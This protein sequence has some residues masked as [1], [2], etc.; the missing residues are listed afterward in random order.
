MKEIAESDHRLKKEDLEPAEK[1]Y[2]EASS[3]VKSIMQDIKLGRSIDTPAAK[4]AIAACVDNIIQRQDALLLMSRLRDRDEYTSQHSLNVAIIAIS[5]GRYSGLEKAKLNEVGLCGLLHDMGKMLTPNHILNKPGKLTDDE[6]EIMRQH[7]ADG[8]NILSSSGGLFPEVI[9]VA[10]THHERMDGGGY[11]RKVPGKNLSLYSR[12]VTIAD[13]FD[14]VT[15]DRIYKDGATIETALRIMYDGRGISFDPILVT[16]FIESV[17]IYPLGT[18]VELQNGE[19]GLVVHSNPEHRLRPWVKIILG[20]D[21]EPIDPLLVD[22]S[23]MDL[24]SSGNPYWIKAS[25]NPR[26][27]DIDLLKHLHSQII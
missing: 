3:L 4:Q 16:Q 1:Y 18:V 13:V 25:H 19:I 9:Q 15:A 17:G 22:L 6:M 23:R 21:H 14:A 7:P 26:N 11:P 5:L 2:K 27:F 24:D 10:H 20:P 12:I 8:Y